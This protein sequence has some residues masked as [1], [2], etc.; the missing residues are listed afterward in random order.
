MSAI[1]QG[2]GISPPYP[3]FYSTTSDKTKGLKM[4]IQALTYANVFSR[5]DLADDIGEVS[6]R[7]NEAFISVVT[8]DTVTAS[9]SI[10]TALLAVEGELETEGLLVTDYAD[11]E[12]GVA[13]SL[14]NLGDRDA[15]DYSKVTHSLVAGTYT[16]QSSF[17]GTGTIVPITI[18]SN[19]ANLVMQSGSNLAS[20]SLAGSGAMTFT[21]YNSTYLQLNTTGI[22]PRK[23]VIPVSN[24]TL[25]L[26]SDDNRWADVIS[27][28]GD[29]SGTI[30]SNVGGDISLYNL[31]T[32]ASNYERGYLRWVSGVLNVGIESAGTGVADVAKYGASDTVNTH[33]RIGPD[34]ARFQVDGLPVFHSTSSYSYHRVN[35]FPYTDD[36]LTF[37][38][39]SNNWK[40]VFSRQVRSNDSLT[41]TA[42]TTI[43]LEDDTNVT[44]DLDVTGDVVMAANVDFTGLPTSD[45]LV[46]GRMWNNSGVAT[47]SAG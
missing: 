34:Y 38:V 35:V 10:T 15:A 27:V 21:A 47:I 8:T 41:L 31:D 32:D 46:A 13:L 12:P 33:V 24:G 6:N 42:A 5:S 7:I 11:L 3:A 2:M 43:E 9:S 36:S 29:F 30:K 4:G 14:Y 20:L 23:D 26:G 39:L 18:D 17:A 45:P 28:D 1:R 40:T 19:G 44:G 22:V 37:G 16:V 25:D